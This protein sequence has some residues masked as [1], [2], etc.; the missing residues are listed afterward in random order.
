ML[1]RAVTRIAELT[2]KHPKLVLAAVGVFTI[3]AFGLS[4]NV[5]QH[6]KAAGFSDPASESSRAQALLI[7]KSGS[8]SQPAIIVRVRP[9]AGQGRLALHSPSLR[10]EA[11]RLSTALR[12]VDGVSRTENPLSGG[13]P[14]LVAPDR[15]SLLLAAYFSSDD[16]QVLA[17]GADEASERL[18]SSKF[19]VTVG[20]LA[21]GFNE[22]NDTVHSDLIRAELIAF[23]LLALL[24]LIVFRGVVAASIPLIVGM[25]SIGGT[26]LTLLVMSKFVDTSV[27]ALNIT[28]AMGLGLAVDYGLLLV[29]RYREELERDGPSRESHRRLVESAG[30]TVIFSG[31]TVAAAMAAVTLLPQRFLYSV[32]AGGAIVAI[33][34]ALGALLIVPS[35]LA[36]LGERVNA[37]SLRRGPALSDESGGWY[38]LAR[39]VMRRP[40]TVAL[41]SA[42][43]LLLLAVPVLGVKLTI[44]GTDS[45]PA[46]KPSR[47]V[48]VTIDRDYPATLGT[49]VSVTVDGSASDSQLRHLS[50]RIAA[51][52]GIGA[53]S[54]FQ[55][56]SPNLA[57]ANFG[58][59]G[60]ADDALTDETQE[61]VR[62]IRA[63]TG[64]APLLVSGFTAEFL[65][66]KESLGRNLPLVIGVIA[67]TTLILLFMLTGSVVLPLKTLLMN[68]LT[69]AGTLGV[70]VAAFQWGLLDGPLG[71]SGPEGMETSTLVL[72]FAVI[73]GLSTDYAVLV[74]ARIKELHDS[75][76]PNEEAVARGI[77]RTGRV[78]SAA[79]ICL[80]AVFL[81]FT[82]SSI[83]FMK[84]AGIGY[85]AAVLIDATLV[86]ALLVP[87]LMR[88]FGDWNWWAPAPLRRFQQRYGFS[89]VS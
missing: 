37:L 10:R 42:A 67:L 22:V 53:P 49:P 87:A 26:F 46:G 89:E 2:W 9:V 79:A 54:P 80:A 29:T 55:R 41:C 16:V 28:T 62:E 32:G 38:R 4:K 64:P 11:R 59:N 33:F 30:R 43:L 20:G 1:E 61:A 14:Q 51:V 13:S 24:L 40:V 86:R 50:R 81:A 63:I 27:F 74:L 70:I 8:E 44:P 60:T 71:Y 36:L 5:E 45:V 3:L 69:L 77:A 85:A 6:L 72:M 68:L 76:L 15:S 7:E 48:V 34:A 18:S 75:G 56:I 88:L 65:D 25:V 82:T 19:E 83:F 58:L 57:L 35:L 21:A 52:K 31:L 12:S 73:F 39:G 66:L 78:I 47:K 23:P 17:N 84:E